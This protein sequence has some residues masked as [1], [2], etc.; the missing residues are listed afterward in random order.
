MEVEE[1]G[2]REAGPFRCTLDLWFMVVGL[3]LLS[4]LARS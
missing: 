3:G 2:G 4:R 1:G